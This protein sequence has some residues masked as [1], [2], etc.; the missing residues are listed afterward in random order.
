MKSSAE[1]KSEN[2]SYLFM[3]ALVAALG[4]F[5]FGF[6][7]AVISGTAGF[8]KNKFLLDALAEGWF[9]GIALLGCIIGV[10]IAGYLSDKF[11]RKPVLMLSAVLFLSSA[12]GCV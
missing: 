6:D 3:L 10:L 8:V 7:T 4:G 5:L 1:Y 11:G 2:S 12:A 9:V